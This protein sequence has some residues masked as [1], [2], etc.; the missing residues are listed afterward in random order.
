MPD[1]LVGNT[2]DMQEEVNALSTRL[3]Q[4]TPKVLTFGEKFKKE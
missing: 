2:K 4:V 3:D 1:I